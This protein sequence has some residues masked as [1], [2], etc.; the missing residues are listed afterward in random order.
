[1]T[2]QSKSVTTRSGL[3]QQVIDS[4]RRRQSQDGVVVA[5]LSLVAGY[6]LAIS[7]LMLVS[8]GTFHADVGPFGVQNDHYIRDG[9][10]F[11]LALGVMAVLAVRR[12]SW[13]VPV[14]VALLLQFS[15][16]A[17][18][19]L[20]DISEADPAWLGPADFIGLTA[21]SILLA[22]LLLLVHRSENLR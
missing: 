18:N 11:Q 4:A 7:L 17:L 10:T 8:P 21:T 15:F 6:L 2:M 13:R 1:M 9:A 12:P 22:W 20:A 19:H 16:H 14:L 3:L 5:G